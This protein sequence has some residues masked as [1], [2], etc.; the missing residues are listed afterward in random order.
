[1]NQQERLFVEKHRQLHALAK[2]S[3]ELRKTLIEAYMH[4]HHPGIHTEIL[5][6]DDNVLALDVTFPGLPENTSDLLVSEIMVYLQRLL[7]PSLNL[8]EYLNTL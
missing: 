5:V 2:E 1:M 8:K 6:M 7:T 4:E 3:S